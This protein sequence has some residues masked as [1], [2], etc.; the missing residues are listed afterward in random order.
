M[1]ANGSTVNVL[2][3]IVGSLTTVS[4]AAPEQANIVSRKRTTLTPLT[5]GAK[6][7][8]DNVFHNNQNWRIPFPT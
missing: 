7:K 2:T 8:T 1:K 4:H 3:C 5:S 6:R